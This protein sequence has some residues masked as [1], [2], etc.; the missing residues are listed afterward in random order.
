MNKEKMMAYLNKQI[1][2]KRSQVSKVEAAMVDSESK[3]ERSQLA[4][5][6]KNI[7]SEIEEAEKALAE[8]EKEDEPAEEQDAE[9]ERG[10]NLEALGTY[11]QRSGVPA[12]TETREDMTKVYEQRGK[13]LKEKRSVTVSSGTVLLPKHTGTMINDTFT[14][15]STLF[16]NVATD[17]L[18]GGESY[19][20]AFVVSYAEGGITEEGADYTTAE[21]TFGYAPMSK[22]K[23]TA[24]AELSEEVQK[25]P[26]ADYYSK[27]EEACLIALRKKISSQILNGTGTKQITGI[28]ASPVAIDSD[29]DVEITAIDNNTVNEALF[30]Y[31]GDEDVETEAKLILN[32]KTLKAL[33]E[34][35]NTDGTPAYNIDV[36]KRTINTIPYIINSNVKDFDSASAGDFVMAYGDPRA[37]KVVT[38]SPV[39]MKESEHYKFKQG[40]ICFRASVFIGGNVIKQDG[41]LRLKKKASQ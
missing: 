28:F 13:D 39:E 21:P 41:L 10:M 36:T 12:K 8:L 26:N 5:T 40:I 31:G 3:E 35:R 1:D 37:Y 15:V 38:F 30:N 9:E 11:E 22:I 16:D 17:D 25:L 4:E 24:Y 14:P 29:R 6:V 32:K 18:P 23:I 33:A 2:E 19:E 7:R 20:E 34:V 27:V